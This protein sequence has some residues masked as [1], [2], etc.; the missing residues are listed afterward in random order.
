MAWTTPDSTLLRRA[1]PVDWRV[2]SKAAKAEAVDFDDVVSLAISNTVGLIRLYVA[3]NPS[4]VLGAEGSIPPE[5]VDSFTKLARIALITSF[6]GTVSLT[7]DVRKQQETQAMKVLEA[8]AK[9][10]ARITPAT[11]TATAQPEEAGGVSG[12]MEAPLNW[13][14]DAVLND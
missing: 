10:G 8:I 4:N 3:G 2:L 6:P 5:T 11:E 1:M 12:S 7:E 14:T 9:G 13:G